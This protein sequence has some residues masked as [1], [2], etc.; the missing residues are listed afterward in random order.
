MMSTAPRGGTSRNGRI[1]S[2]G[3]GSEGPGPPVPRL[4]LGEVATDILVVGQPAGGALLRRR[5]ERLVR[6][7]LP[8]R[9]GARLDHRLQGLEGVV[10]IGRLE[11]EVDAHLREFTGG[12]LVEA[13]ARAVADAL[14]RELTSGAGGN[15]VHFESTGD[16]LAAYVVDRFS[17]RRRPPWV[18]AELAPLG[19]LAAEDAAAELL[20]ARPMHLPALARQLI[21][22]PG[23]AGFALALG[24]SRAR[25]VLEAAAGV[26]FPAAPDLMALETLLAHPRPS[27]ATPHVAGLIC[28]LHHHGVG[29]G[30]TLDRMGPA[31]LFLAGALVELRGSR[32]DGGSEDS[33]SWP[34]ASTSFPIHLDALTHS[35]H[36]RRILERLRGSVGGPVPESSPGEAAL[37]STPSAPSP[38][39]ADLRTPTRPRGVKRES[40]PTSPPPPPPVTGALRYTFAGLALALPVV[41]AL[42]LHAHLGPARLRLCLTALVESQSR[43]LLTAEG[44]LIL[45][46]PPDDEGEGD[47]SVEVDRPWPSLLSQHRMGLDAGHLGE[48]EEALMARSE[49]QAYASL[50]AGHLAHRLYG[51]SRSSLPYLRREFLQ[52]A[53]WVQLTDTEIHVHLD[54]VPLAVVLRLSGQLGDRGTLPWAGE[55]RLRITAGEA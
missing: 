47:S 19:H 11:V 27:A 9:L 21:G 38:P 1:R 39:P 24:E 51:L 55:R 6:E 16:Y 28:L 13:W 40:E 34:G 15:L 20:A 30:E 50:L 18:F 45:F 53:G 25:R 48:V 7:V 49:A 35:L 42:D 33:H 5:L 14:E 46:I 43:P 41:R 22:G 31:A 32:G 3:D 23:V 17:G 26:A 2:H 8:Q 52:R 12:A 4:T 10:R 54:P 37:D 29:S 36:G 44:L